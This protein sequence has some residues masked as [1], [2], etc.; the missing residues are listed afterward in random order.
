M[1]A[2]PA[3][4]T[5]ESVVAD[6]WAAGLGHGLRLAD[7][8]EL[9]VIFPGIPGGG[10]GPDFRD[11]ILEAD[12]DLLRG[13]VEVHLLESGWRAHGHHHDPAYANVV[14]H[15]AGENPGGARTTLHASRAIPILVLGLQTAAPAAAFTPPCVIWSA[16]GGAAGPALARLGRRRLRMKAARA[17]PLM[18]AGGAGQ[19]LYEL[20]LETL[21]GPANRTAFAALAGR[22]PLAALLER[23]ADSPGREGVMAAA[24]RDAAAE[25]PLQYAGVRPAAAPGRRL[26]AAGNLAAQLWPA[27]SDPGWPPLLSP[28]MK[29]LS[30][31]SRALASELMANAVLPV[32]LAAHAWDEADV[33][34]A[35][36]ALASPGTYG[37]LRPLESWLAAGGARPFGSAS[38]LQGGLLLHADYC[39]RGA[40]GRC[41]LSS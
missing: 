13:D 31:V 37:R 16:Q 11:A 23:A 41:P 4:R 34:S 9:R 39:T 15:V 30:G 36:E 40:C 35:Y 5:G 6:A 12:G 7:G 18:A 32:A 21:G 26:E 10:Q 28:G 27:G 33:Y 1:T 20:L 29:T 14:L 38:A 2:V 17:Q 3:T 8:R 19:A 24:L 22:L 25:L